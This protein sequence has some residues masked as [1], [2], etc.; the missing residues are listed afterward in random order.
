[1]EISD[2]EKIGNK[3]FNIINKY[4]IIVFGNLEEYE[5]DELLEFNANKDNNKIGLDDIYYY[6]Y[7]LNLNL[8]IK[9]KYNNK[10]K[11]IHN[12]INYENKKRLFRKRCSKYKI[13]KN[14]RLLKAVKIS[15][16][17]DE[18]DVIKDYAIIPPKLINK[19]LENF[20]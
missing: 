12:G 11:S 17:F 1:M 14:K 7:H 4:K 13:D 18:K 5:F 6:L 3:D 15:Y 8:I 16:I 10:Y 19:T 2:D 20:P 9:G